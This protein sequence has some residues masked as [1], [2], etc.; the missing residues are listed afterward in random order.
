MPIPNTLG[1][2]GKPIPIKH[3]SLDIWERTPQRDDWAAGDNFLDW[4]DH[5]EANQTGTGDG[6][7]TVYAFSVLKKL[8]GAPCS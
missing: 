2:N 8:L 3:R 7:S 6:V 1:V 4:D 5:P